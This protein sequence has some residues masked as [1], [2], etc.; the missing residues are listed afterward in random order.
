MLVLVAACWVAAVQAQQSGSCN[1]APNDAC[2]TTGQSSTYAETINGDTREIR[3]MGCP[4]SNPLTNCLGDNPSMAAEQDW[5]FD[6]PAT[7]RF[8]ASTYSASL[9]SATSLGAVGGLIG[10]TLNGVEVRSCYG[11][12][13]YGECSDW[14]SSAVLFE[15]DTFEYCGGHGNPHHYH[16]APVCLLEQMGLESDGSSPQVGWAADG[17]PLMGPRGP[18]GVFVKRCGETGADATY[19]VDECGGYYGAWNGNDDF[20]YRY[21]LMGDDAVVMDNPLSP[22]PT[23]DFFPHAPLCLVGCGDVYAD[24]NDRNPGIGREIDSCGSSASDG[25]AAGYSPVALGGVTTAFA[26]YA[27]SSDDASSSSSNDDGPSTSS[28]PS[29]DDF[30]G[31]AVVDDYADEEADGAPRAAPLA[32]ALAAA[33]LFAF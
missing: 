12:T 27:T 30:V 24:G 15:S 10:M 1:S 28:S 21:F 3:A 11:G 2:S 8:K 32:S 6:I 16:N 5:E 20:L 22:T 13:A 4:N 25:T 33:V 19:C 29:N 9:S 31:P 26:T 23:S 18:G 7:P 17:F 14:S